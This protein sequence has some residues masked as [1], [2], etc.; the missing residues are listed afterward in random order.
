M[1]SKIAPHAVRPQATT[2]L[3]PYGAND[4]GSRKT[5]EPML[6]PTTRATHI[7]KPSNCGCALTDR[8]GEIVIALADRIKVGACLSISRGRDRG[9]FPLR[10]GGADAVGQ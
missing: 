4:A 1:A 5:P 10:Q 8:I 9:R 2:L 7:Q 3:R 6:L